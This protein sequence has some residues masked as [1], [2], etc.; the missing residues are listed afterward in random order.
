MTGNRGATKRIVLGFVCLV[1]G[2]ILGVCAGG[3]MPNP[4]GNG[5]GAAQLVVGIATPVC[6]SFV[7][8]GLAG[9]RATVA[10]VW[11]LGSLVLSGAL[12][13]FVIWFVRTYVPT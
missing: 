12:V 6:L 1:I 2:P 13:F 10:T 3:S 9:I 11:A 8:C 7:V 4:P 5:P